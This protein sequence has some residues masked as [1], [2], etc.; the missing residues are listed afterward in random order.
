MANPF[1]R[2][3]TEYVRDDVTF[4]SMVSPAPLSNIFASS[5]LQEQAFSMPVRLIGRPGTGKTMIAMITEFRLVETVALNSSDQNK[6]LAAALNDAGFLDGNLPKVASVRIPMESQYRQ[7]WELPYAEQTRTQL[8]LRLVQARTVLSLIR[9]LTSGDRSIDDIEFVPRSGAEA[10]TEAIGGTKATDLRK[11]A[12]LVQEAVYGVVANLIPPKEDQLPSDATEPY[13]P[14]QAIEHVEIGWSGQRLR[15]KPLVMLDDVH[16]LHPDQMVEMLGELARRE[17]RF[18]RWMIMRLDTFDPKTVLSSPNEIR[19]A[20]LQSGRDYV[21]VRLQSWDDRAEA[22]RRFRKTGKE[23]SERYLPLVRSLDSRRATRLEPL[24][25]TAVPTLPEGKRRELRERVEA[26]RLKLSI[27]SSMHDEIE[28]LIDAFSAKRSVDLPQDV[29]FVSV[30]ILLNRYANRIAKGTPDLFGEHSSE[31]TVPLSMKSEIA[32]AAEIAL[33][34]QYERP[35]YYGFNVLC[36]ASDENTEQ[37]LKL[38]GA[39]VER[40]EVLAITG[41]NL[42]LK[43]RDQHRILRRKAVDLIKEWNFPFA[44]SA[45]RLIGRMGEACHDVSVQPNARLGAGANAWGVPMSEMTRLLE[46]DDELAN[47]LKYA[48]AYGVVNVQRDYGQGGRK[49][50]LIELGGAVCL[51]HGLTFRRGGFLERKVD[52]LRKAVA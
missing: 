10:Q 29:R 52:D 48:H 7:F 16:S 38:A 35:F 51:A 9:N 26:T 15:L 11:R 1:L 43:P 41:K 42:Q 23:L 3:A 32:E 34:H 36:D 28:K 45:R 27:A 47:V 24:L 40:L 4:L 46:S 50:A 14:F 25:S 31:P 33:M 17:I 19:T 5:D 2:R 8:C 49:W 21:D 44:S 20:N 12:L 13:E 6:D 18:G 30:E 39:L 37:F 22:R